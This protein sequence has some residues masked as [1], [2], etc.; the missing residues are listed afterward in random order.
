M[1]CEICGSTAGVHYCGLCKTNLCATCARR[2][3]YRAIAA[4]KKLVG[5]LTQ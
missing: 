5:K 4:A 2:W 1:K 3:D